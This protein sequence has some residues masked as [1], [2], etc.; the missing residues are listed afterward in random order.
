MSRSQDGDDTHLGEEACY[1][2]LAGAV[3]FSVLLLILWRGRGGKRK[4]QPRQRAPV[5][6]RAARRA[7]H[8][9]ECCLGLGPGT[10]SRLGHGRKVSGIHQTSNIQTPVPS[11]SKAANCSLHAHGG[12]EEQ[13]P[14]SSGR[15]VTM[16]SFTLE[17]VESPSR[18]QELKTWP[19]NGIL[20]P[21]HVE[22]PWK[23]TKPPKR[24]SMQLEAIGL[25]Q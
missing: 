21:S 2:G 6:C 18:R 23:M 19:A 15:L 25:L 11:G 14:W 10:P 17:R 4:P 20:W 22:S 5:V 16:M 24:H 12:K 7:G 9:P 3:F 1:P 13:Q 8:F